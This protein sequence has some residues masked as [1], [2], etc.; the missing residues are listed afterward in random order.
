MEQIEFAQWKW[1]GTKDVRDQSITASFNVPE[2]LY[3]IIHK[4]NNKVL[5]LHVELDWNTIQLDCSLST[6]WSPISWTKD[7]WWLIK[8]DIIVKDLLLL[9]YIIKWTIHLNIK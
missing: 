9:W 8:L 5:E 3:N 6:T 1:I 7:H 4:Y 2:N